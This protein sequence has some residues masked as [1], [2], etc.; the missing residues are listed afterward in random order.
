[1]FTPTN[2]QIME[3]A[4]RFLLEHDIHPLGRY[5][6]WEYSSMAK[7]IGDGFALGERLRSVAPVTAE[8]ARRKESI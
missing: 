6:N 1:V 2:R 4:R 8:W 7:V 3:R 5:G